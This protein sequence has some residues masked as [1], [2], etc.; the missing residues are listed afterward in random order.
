MTY[1]VVVQSLSRIQLFVTPWTA[2]LQ[3]SLSI[4][5]FQSLLKF[6]SIELVILT[7]HLILCHPFLLLPFPN[8]SQAFKLIICKVQVI[9]IIFW[10]G[11]LLT[12]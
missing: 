8:R 12:F 3:A 11:G 1:F 7:N 6:M 4:T 2:A 9:Y 5:I 10:P